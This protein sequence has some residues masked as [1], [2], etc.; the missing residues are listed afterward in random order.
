[1]QNKMKPTI[2]IQM[3]PGSVLMA[4]CIGLSGCASER[5]KT[6]GTITAVTTP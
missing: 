5:V 3:G 6:Q 2:A 1:M 4:L